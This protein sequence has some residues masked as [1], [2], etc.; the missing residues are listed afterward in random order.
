[1]QVLTPVR[2]G[3]YAP[4]LSRGSRQNQQE[5]TKK[6]GHHDILEE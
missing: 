3:H 2:D 4:G 1:M 5:E 6:P